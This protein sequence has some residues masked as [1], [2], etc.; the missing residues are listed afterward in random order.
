VL[1]LT[2]SFPHPRYDE[3]KPNSDCNA[4]NKTA[5]SQYKKDPGIQKQSI[6]IKKNKP[7]QT[8][9]TSLTVL[10]RVKDW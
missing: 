9:I 5:L 7:S 2:E 4:L 10:G 8:N 6:I 3:Q 1:L